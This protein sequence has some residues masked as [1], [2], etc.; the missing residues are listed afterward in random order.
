MNH[1]LK[2]LFYTGIIIV[3][4][5]EILNVY[6]IMPMPGSQEIKSIDIAYF[7]YTHRWYFRIACG[8]MITSGIVSAFNKKFRILPALSLVAAIAVIC[9]FNFRMNAESMFRQPEKLTLKPKAE[10]IVGDSSL[11]ICVENNGKVKAYPIRFMSYHHQ[12]QDTVGELPL[13]ITYCNVCRT[14]RAFRPVVQ[15]HNEKFR[16]VGMDHYNAMFEDAT[17]G[18][19][20]RQ[21][22]GEAI[23]GTLKG[24]A[25]PEVETMQLTVKKLFELYP[26]ALVMQAD[27]ASKMKYDTLGKFEQGK[28]ISRLTHTIGTFSKIDTSLMT[29]SGPYQYYLSYRLMDKALQLSKGLM[30]K[31]C[32]PYGMILSIQALMPMISQEM[33]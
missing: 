30:R 14:G 17:T 27:E 13:I 15:G 18:S 29:K 1:L 28:S 7:L 6:F 12:V 11:V 19:W 26:D 9:L 32:F 2:I 33:E 3:I 23:A 5:F 16:L 24:E 22:T 4:V 31:N 21:S 25:L 10:N 8:I 20:W